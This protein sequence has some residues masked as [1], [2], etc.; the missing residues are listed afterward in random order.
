MAKH[1]H[2]NVREENV[3]SRLDTGKEQQRIRALNVLR[4]CED[5]LANQVAMKLIET[6][7][8]ETNNK[9]ELERQLTATLNQLVY[10]DDFDIQYQISPF[11]TVVPRPNFI[12]LYLTAFIVEKLINHKSII[13]IFGTDEDIYNAVNTLVLKFVYDRI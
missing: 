5:E 1:Y 11:R 8:V 2:P 3:I 12:S 9:R 13:D 7:L 6:G 4:D 10:A